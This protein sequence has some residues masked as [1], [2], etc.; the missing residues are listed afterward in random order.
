VLSRVITSL[1]A[2]FA[3][4]AG[5]ANAATTPPALCSTRRRVHF[6]CGIRTSWTAHNILSSGGAPGQPPVFDEPAFSPYTES[7]T[8]SIHSWKEKI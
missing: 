5:H 6:I 3:G 4:R 8:E 7:E 1:T 2:A